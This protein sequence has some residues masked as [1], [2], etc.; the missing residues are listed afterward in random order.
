MLWLLRKSQWDRQQR[1]VKLMWSPAWFPLLPLPALDGH[2]HW[3]NGA[4]YFRILAGWPVNFTHTGFYGLG[5]KTLY[6]PYQACSI[7][8]LFHAKVP[9][10]VFS[11][12]VP[13]LSLKR[14]CPLSCL[15]ILCE[16]KHRPKTENWVSRA[17]NGISGFVHQL[18]E[19]A[20]DLLPPHAHTLTL[21]K[22]LSSP[23]PGLLKNRRFI[24][25][26]WV[27]QRYRWNL[28]FPR[29]LLMTQPKSYK[30]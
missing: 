2:F 3:P 14:E 1:L 13:A 18:R 4:F 29:A 28:G 8:S 16:L 7:C 22:P 10:K 6:I 5:S 21:H 30:G 15:R 24:F 9:C 27:I 17:S 23:F 26:A 19:S 20:L 25:M 11:L 12:S